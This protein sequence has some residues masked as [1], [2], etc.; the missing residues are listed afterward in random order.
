MFQS[1]GSTGMLYMKWRQ[2]AQQR[3]MLLPYAAHALI[4][5]FTRAR[6]QCEEAD[7]SVIRAPTNKKLTVYKLG[8]AHAHV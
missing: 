2:E 1:H 5:T 4:S 6:W 8:S 3:N 7:E